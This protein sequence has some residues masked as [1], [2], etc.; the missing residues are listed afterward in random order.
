MDS[1]IFVT[2]LKVLI[3][4]FLIKNKVVILVSWW[5]RNLND[6]LFVIR[7]FQ[8]GACPN[9]LT[10]LLGSSEINLNSQCSCVVNNI[11]NPFSSYTEYDLRSVHLSSCTLPNN[12]G[13]LK[14]GTHY[15]ALGIKQIEFRRKC[16]IRSSTETIWLK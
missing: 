9:L 7:T 3:L 10:L 6:R 12:H 2:M 5:Y 15:S 8:D 13:T 4:R 11:E 1:L 14:A 16:K